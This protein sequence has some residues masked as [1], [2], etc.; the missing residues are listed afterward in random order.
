MQVA[1]GN[2]GD[3]EYSGTDH[4]N[5]AGLGCRI[6]ASCLSYGMHVCMLH[7]VVQS[8]HVFSSSVM[9]LLFIKHSRITEF[10]SEFVFVFRWK[11]MEQR[12]N[13]PRRFLLS[14]I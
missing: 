14:L 2:E 12:M 13:Y 5:Y 6:S 3:R 4:I 7:D 8:L 1:G 9:F 10:R 11:F